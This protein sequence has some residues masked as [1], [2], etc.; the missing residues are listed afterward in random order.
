[1]GAAISHH[2]QVIAAAVAAEGGSVVKFRG[3]GAHAVFP[4]ARAAV[5][6]AIS[7]QQELGGATGLRLRA[8]M[9]V[10][11]GEAELLGGTTTARQ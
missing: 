4:S 8:R 10:H 1:M 5:A 3:D 7:C 9:G 11:T 2:E 6:A